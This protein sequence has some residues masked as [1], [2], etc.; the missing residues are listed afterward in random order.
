MKY[1]I[2]DISEQVYAFEAE[3]TRP[4]TDEEVSKLFNRTP[5]IEDVIDEKL[6]II[7]AA[8]EASINAGFIC[9]ALG[10]DVHY[11]CTRD[12]QAMIRDAKTE[13]GGLLWRNET[14]TAHTSTQ[15]SNVFTAMINHRDAVCKS[16]YALKMIYIIDPIRTIDEINAVTW[17]SSE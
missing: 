5:N 6:Y 13:G 9:S 3:D 2:N 10:Y 16:K 14:L 11:R 7:R 17:V 8:C 12:D 1:Y 15:A 4:M